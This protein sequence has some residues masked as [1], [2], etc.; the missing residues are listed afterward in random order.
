VLDASIIRMIALM[1]EAA[2]TYETLMNFYQTTQCNNPEDSHLDTRC[3]E[4]LKS[5]IFVLLIRPVYNRFVSAIN[6]HGDY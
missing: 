1:M 5:H 4:N 2:G 3:C 6:E